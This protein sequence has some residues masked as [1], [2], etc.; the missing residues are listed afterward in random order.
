MCGQIVEAQTAEITQLRTWLCE[1]YGVCNYGPKGAADD[2][3]ALSPSPGGPLSR[4][5]PVH[6]LESRRR[7][8]MKR[9]MLVSVL[10][11]CVGAALVGTASQQK[12]DMT[13]CQDM[14]ARHQKMMEEMKAMDAR[15][16][17]EMTAM[18]AAQGQAKVDAIAR[19][20]TTLVEQRTH[21]RDRAMVMHAQ[22]S[23]HMMEHAGQGPAAMKQCPMMQ[24]MMMKQPPQ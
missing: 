15:L 11:V 10:W 19:V 9:A 17:Q 6:R 3:C 5:P 14:A 21:M 8:I 1:W 18:Q 16:D 24:Q 23:G 7:S 2:D 13:M 20:V 22:A 12:P 4:G